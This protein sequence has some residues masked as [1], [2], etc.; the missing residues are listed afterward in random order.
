MGTQMGALPYHLAGLP[1]IKD[2]LRDMGGSDAVPEE[3]DQID[4]LQVLT[5]LSN[6]AGFMVE[7]AVENKQK[8]DNTKTIGEAK[9]ISP[10]KQKNTDNVGRET[11]TKTETKDMSSPALL[12][13]GQMLGDLPS[14][15]KSSPS[16]NNMA[17][18]RELDESLA[19]DS[20]L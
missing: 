7:E 8:T 10:T 1:T 5:E 6:P 9:N 3:N 20:S 12:H 14:L 15:Q 11:P 19:K 16:K 4:M 17:H 2:M 13:S 18:S